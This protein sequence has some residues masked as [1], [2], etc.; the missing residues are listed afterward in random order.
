MGTDRR[1]LIVVMAAAGVIA[2]AGVYAAE[3]GAEPGSGSSPV[4]PAAIE[5]MCSPVNISWPS[6]GTPSARE[7]GPTLSVVSADFRPKD[8]PLFLDGRFVGRARYFNGKKGF[9]YLQPGRYQLVAASD[10]LKTEVFSIDARPGCRFDI[11]HRMVKGQQGR[12]EGYE[13]PPGQGKPQQWIY[14]PT[15]PSP[16]AEAVGRPSPGP[17]PSLR[18]DLG[19]TKSAADLTRHPS[20]SLRVRVQPSSATVFMDGRLLAT[21]EEI[22]RMVGPFAVPTGPH[23]ILVRAPGF[24]DRTVT[25]ELGQGETEEL[26]VVLAPSGS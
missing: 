5:V 18:P 17:D 1:R 10:G 21:G 11:K 4:K 25:I 13:A 6:S 7:P 23:T 14:A 15:G 24:T 3:E 19:G 16:Q 2:A 8:V 22:A 20:G 12:E 26:E 9:L